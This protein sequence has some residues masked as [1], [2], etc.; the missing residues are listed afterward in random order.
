MIRRPPRSTLFPYTTL[1]RSAQGFAVSENDN[2]VITSGQ[3]L[4]LN[5]AMTIEVEQEKIQVSDT[6]PTLHVNP[7]NN[8]GAIVI[9]EKE[10]HALPDD[11]DELL[12]ELKALAGLESGHLG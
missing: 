10:H 8:A 12:T 11:P 5:V 1:F 2:V 4:R 9:S 3:P 6:T 7:A